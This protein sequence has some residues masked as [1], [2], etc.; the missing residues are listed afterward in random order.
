M[1]LT[2][3]DF[4]NG[5]FWLL[6]GIVNVG[7]Y[8]LSDGYWVSIVGMVISLTVL[9]IYTGINTVRDRKPPTP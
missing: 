4:Y 5:L 9:I 6:A 7:S 2:A 8:L 3:K 1:P